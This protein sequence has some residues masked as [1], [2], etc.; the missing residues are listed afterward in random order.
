VDDPRIVVVVMIEHPGKGGSHFAHIAKTLVQTYLERHL[1]SAR[2][3]HRQ[4]QALN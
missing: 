4:T 3:S 1:V 2:M